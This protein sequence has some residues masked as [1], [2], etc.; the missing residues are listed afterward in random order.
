M[1]DIQW[2]ILIYSAICVTFGAVIAYI[3]M[4]F[5]NNKK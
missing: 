4:K 3:I 2:F 1:S 5:L